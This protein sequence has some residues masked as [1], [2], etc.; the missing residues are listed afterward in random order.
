MSAVA[1]VEDNAVMRKTLRQWIEAAPGFRCVFACA[2]AEEALAE[3][4]RVKPDVVLMDIHLPGQ[5]GIACTAQLK[6]K[7]PSVQIIMLTVYRNHDLLIQALQ[8]GACGYLLKAL[9]PGRAFESDQR[10]SLRQ[11]DDQRDR[12]H[13][14]Q[15]FQKKPAN[16]VASDGLTQRESEILSL[17][18]EG[19]RNKE[20]ADR[21]K[22][23]YDTVRAHL[24]H[25]YEKLHVRG[26]TEAVR[27]YLK[28]S[29]PPS[30]GI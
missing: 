28:S 9:Q 27:R 11:A 22:I 29:N 24:R 14:G 8:A 18:S 6:E 3:L 25:I 10:S 5:S 15:A 21:L 17:L 16:V 26:R 2:T 7:L 13:V 30:G 1:I 20:I 23:S 19:L 4:P 12:P